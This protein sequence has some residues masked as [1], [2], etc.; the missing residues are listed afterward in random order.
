MSFD[1]AESILGAVSEDVYRDQTAAETKYQGLEP[2]V[3]PVLHACPR[4]GEHKVRADTRL[5]QSLSTLDDTSRSGQTLALVHFTSTVPLFRKLLYGLQVRHPVNSG[6]APPLRFGPQLA[7]LPRRAQANIENLGVA[8]RRRIDRRAALRTKGL[9]ALCPALGGFHVNLGL[10]CDDMERALGCTNA[11]TKG[12]TRKRLTIRAMAYPNILGVDFRSVGDIPAM[13]AAVDL[14]DSLL[15]L[16]FNPAIPATQ[17]VNNGS[18][19]AAKTSVLT[20][21]TPGTT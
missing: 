11:G 8:R 9:S 2:P 20:S 7:A 14:H 10:S 1:R 15:P 17:G 6:A 3:M 12:R 5:R 4:A 19:E 13:A 21:V 16:I 18:R